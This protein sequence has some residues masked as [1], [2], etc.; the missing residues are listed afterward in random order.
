L[1]EGFMLGKWFKIISVP[2]LLVLM[3]AAQTIPAGTAPTV[4]VGSEISSGTAKVG[5]RFDGTLAHSLVVHGKTLAGA[6][7]PVK[8]KVPSAKS[9]GRL[10]AS[11]DLRSG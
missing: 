1:K 10:H 11:G 3:A 5:D 9:S 8:G 6:G 4:R 2:M 7:A